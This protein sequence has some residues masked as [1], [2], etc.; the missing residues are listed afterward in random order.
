M[1]TRES[2]TILPGIS[3]TGNRVVSC[4]E[5]LCKKRTLPE[6]IQ[7]D[8]SSEFYSKSMDSWVYRHGG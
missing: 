1:F 4:L 5:D 7:V 6:R 2:L 3:L 8:K